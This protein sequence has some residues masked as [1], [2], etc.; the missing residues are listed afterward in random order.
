MSKSPSLAI[1][2]AE[3]K[4]A[5]DLNAELVDYLERVVDHALASSKSG[6]PYYRPV[7]LA[8]AARVI[9]KAKGHP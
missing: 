7:L 4:A 5:K 3:L 9:A 1:L 2:R 8:G 6:T